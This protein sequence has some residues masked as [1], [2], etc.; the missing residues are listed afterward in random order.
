MTLSVHPFLRNLRNA[1]LYFEDYLFLNK[2]TNI[3]DKINH[4]RNIRN[5]RK[6]QVIQIVEKHLNC[7]INLVDYLI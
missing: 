4:V 5:I 6:I 7:F 3:F 1:F 2:N